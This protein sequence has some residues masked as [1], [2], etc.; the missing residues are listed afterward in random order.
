MD[1]TSDESLFDRYRRGDTASLRTIIERHHVELLRFLVR[2]VGDQAGAEDVFQETFLQVHLS[3]ASFDT[4]R[5]F[6]PWLFTI[7]A[8][9]ARDYLRRKGRRRTLELSAPVGGGGDDDGG[10]FIDLMEVRIPSPQQRLDDDETSRQVQ[11][12]LDILS[13]SL[14]EI[15]LLA[16]FQRLS[17]QQIADD[18]DIP[19]GTVKS[20]LHAAVASF[21]K[22]WKKTQDGTITPGQ[23]R[24]QP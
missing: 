14:K 23:P 5:R 16:Y 11:T 8:N 10:S 17:Y 1:P 12:A 9:K 7:A 21:A 2:L 4:S 6:R 15:L 3:A 13:P 22:A 24:P 20:R 19:L 18:L